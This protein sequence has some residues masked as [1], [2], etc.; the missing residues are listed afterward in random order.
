MQQFSQ[1]IHNTKVAIDK[2]VAIGM[3]CST[4]ACNENC[5]VY[6]NDQFEHSVYDARYSQLAIKHD[7]FMPRSPTMHENADLKN[8]M[9]LQDIF[10]QLKPLHSIVVQ[11]GQG[12]TCQPCKG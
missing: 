1:S 5:Q 12:Q 7:T 2:N 10:F 9:H 3:V 4:H 6:H 11:I 8:D